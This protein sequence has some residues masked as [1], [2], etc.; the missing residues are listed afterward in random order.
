MI[1]KRREPR[2]VDR[3]VVDAEAERRE[4]VAG[5]MREN[6][7]I[8]P[9]YFYDE[10]GCALYGA[11]CRLPEYYPTRTE[12]G[13]F[14]AR[15][16]EIAAAI[17]PG[18]QFVDLGAGDCRKAEGWL[19][20]VAPSRYVAV[21]I[22]LP[23]IAGALERL[24]A[25]FPGLE[26]VGVATDFSHGLDLEGI[27]D[28]GPALYF[29]PGSS[30]GNFTP[31][32]ATAFLAGIHRQCATRPGSSLLIGV[33]GKKEKAV[34]DAAYDD[35]LGVTAAFNR[36]VL[37]HLNAKFGF[38]FDLAGFSHVGF[39]DEREGRIEMHLESLREQAV[40]LDGHERRFR[41]GERIHT[42]NSYKYAPAEFEAILADAGFGSVRRWD[43]PAVAY[44]VFL[45]R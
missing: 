41:R 18:R 25:D 31:D 28:A 37:R 5:L 35:A 6:A 17:G 3:L 4:L 26:R 38:G 29:Y 20:F 40:R 33:D 14:Q 19:P 43:A 23:E 16:A 36:N 8:S 21:D 13:L 32:E 24:G 10:V 2:L 7:A 45:A 27:L 42:E 30:I 39:Y 15:R 12:V 44:S 1:A 22:A 34:L 9:K 11:I